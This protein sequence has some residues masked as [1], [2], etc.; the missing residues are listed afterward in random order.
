MRLCG[1]TKTLGGGGSHPLADVL[2]C[3]QLTGVVSPSTSKVPGVLRVYC[4]GIN[5]RW[6]VCY[7]MGFGDLWP[8]LQASSFQNIPVKEV[9]AQWKL[10]F[11]SKIYTLHLSDMF[12]SV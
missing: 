7:N 9:K 2:V 11:F 1:E 10:K 5:V 12:Y 8:R 4:P 6:D 3:L